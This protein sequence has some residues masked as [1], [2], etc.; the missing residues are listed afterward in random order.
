M[1]KTLLVVIMAV[2]VAAA[3][4]AQSPDLTTFTDT[5]QGFTTAVAGTLAS[6]A[7][8]GLNWDQAYIGQFPHLGLG[9]TVGASLIPVTAVQKITDMMGVTL[10][11]QLQAYGVPIPAATLDARIGGFFLP[12]DI[13]LEFGTIPDA[14]KNLLG[15]IQLNYMMAG[16]DIRFA[17]LKD[18]G[19]TP[20]LSVGAGYAFFQGSIGVP[21][22]FPGASV[23]ITQLMNA[24]GYGG[25]NTLTFSDPD[26]QFNWQSNVIEAKVQLSKTLLF[27]TPSIG[28]SAAYGISTAGGGLS[29]TISY[30][31]SATTAQ[32]Q[33]VLQAA[34]LPVPTDQSLSVSSSSNGWAFRAFGGIN[35][36]LLFLNLDA[37]A[38]YNV[39]NGSYGGSVSLR[40]QI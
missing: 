21:G 30:S 34:G 28:F 33:S 32:M 2:A 13:G 39:V 35:I 7:T 31:G 23:D 17:L 19:F 5:F 15:G 4:P 6:T 36:A 24:A 14:A 40:F 20:A 26:L 22:L 27:I 12:F 16:G 1:R 18:H 38:F 37:N 25:T 8:I 9:V 3:L 11:A 10:P 29:S